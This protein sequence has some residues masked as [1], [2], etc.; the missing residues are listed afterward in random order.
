MR[1]VTGERRTLS[2]QEV[3]DRQGV[4]LAE[5]GDGGVLERLLRE[6]PV[7]GGD[8]LLVERVEVLV[9][10]DLLHL[11]GEGDLLELGLVDLAGRGEAEEACE[12]EGAEFHAAVVVVISDVVVS[13]QADG[14]AVNDEIAVCGY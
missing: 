10:V 7:R 14:E 4:A 6:H 13:L 12:S 1:R 8:V 3:V 11:L 9:H 5:D 2:V